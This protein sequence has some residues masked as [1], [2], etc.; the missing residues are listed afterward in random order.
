MTDQMELEG[1]L[2]CLSASLCCI[3]AKVAAVTLQPCRLMGDG[4]VKKDLDDAVEFE[5]LVCE[6]VQ[7]P[8]YRVFVIH[9]IEQTGNVYLLSGPGICLRKI[10]DREIYVSLSLGIYTN[11]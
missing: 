9:S 10:V 11:K 6:P 5:C 4:S 1:S 8:P 3:L 7:A 2:L